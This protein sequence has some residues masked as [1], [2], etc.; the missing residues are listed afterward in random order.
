LTS[1][2]ARL[3]S[4]FLLQEPSKDRFPLPSV[5]RYSAHVRFVSLRA[6]VDT[7]HPCKPLIFSF[8]P[9]A[10][11]MDSQ[12]LP[13]VKTLS[14]LHRFLFLYLCWSGG[15]LI[16]GF[17][18]TNGISSDEPAPPCLWYLSLSFDEFT[19]VI[20]LERQNSISVSQILFIVFSGASFPLLLRSESG[21]RFSS[22]DVSS[23]RLSHFP[24]LTLIRLTLA[25][26]HSV[27]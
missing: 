13:R 21:F 12:S 5:N 10:N 17:S 24:S 26:I 9:L 15:V 8:G 7:C 2:I 4:P 22:L 25:G 20:F 6:Y 11:R 19:Y 23:A 27:V 16:L 3:S 14:T 18:V 1:F